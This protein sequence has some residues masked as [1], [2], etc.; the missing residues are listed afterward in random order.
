MAL[1]TLSGEEIASLRQQLLALVAEHRD[2]DQ[3]ISRLTEY[4]PA[5]ELLLRRMKKHKLALKDRI[6]QIELM[7][8]PDIPA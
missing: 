7:L 3:A 6:L 8:T 4:P 5:D 1:H 2:L